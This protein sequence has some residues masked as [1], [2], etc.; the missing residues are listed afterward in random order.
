MIDPK[1]FGEPSKASDILIKILNLADDK[2]LTRRICNVIQEEL[3]FLKKVKA[4]DDLNF[5]RKILAIFKAHVKKGSNPP[6][7]APQDIQTHLQ[8]TLLARI[9]DVERE[10]IIKEKK[11]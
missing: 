3:I 6:I 9:R 1:S 10:I 11:K 7:K 2:N 4:I 5:A 8:S